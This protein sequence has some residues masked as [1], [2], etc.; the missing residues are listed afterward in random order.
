M[1][2]NERIERTKPYFVLF[3]VSAEEDAIY[4]VARFP[5]NWSVPDVNSIKSSFNVQLA[6]MNGGICFATETKNGSDCVFDALDYVIKFNKC[7]EERK[8]LLQEKVKEL[9]NLFATEDV[10]RLKT[11][12]FTFEE[13]KKT[14]GRKSKTQEP[15]VVE[16]QQSEENT[17]TEEGMTDSNVEKQESSDSSLMSFAKNIVE[18]E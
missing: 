6:P 17:N 5:Q 13:P 16:A 7:V 1:N 3:N 4:A 9:K 11:L 10:E 12:T 18:E 15:T 2:L 14:K 8:I